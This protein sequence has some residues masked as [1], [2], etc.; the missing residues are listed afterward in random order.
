MCDNTAGIIKYNDME[1]IVEGE[2]S[3]DSKD[4]DDDDDMN[5]TKNDASTSSSELYSKNKNYLLC[6][7][8]HSLYGAGLFPLRKHF[9][10]KYG[11]TLLFTG[12][13]ILFK[14][15]LLGRLMTWWVRYD[16]IVHR[17]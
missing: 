17:C 8:P 16:I 7:F 13:D 3:D 11:M 6:Y 1:L 15:P 5:Y 9:Q 4:V 2:D 10:D 12:A 14:V